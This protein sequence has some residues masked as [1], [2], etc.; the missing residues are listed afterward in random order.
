MKDDD[1]ALFSKMQKIIGKLGIHSIL[2]QL[3]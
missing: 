3:L 2:I 1:Q